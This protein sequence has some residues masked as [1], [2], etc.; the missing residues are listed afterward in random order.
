MGCAL[1]ENEIASGCPQTYNSAV[2][3]LAFPNTQRES[4]P[5]VMTFRKT[6]RVYQSRLLDQSTTRDTCL[7]DEGF[8]EFSV[9][10]ISRFQTCWR[11]RKRSQRSSRNAGNV[12]SVQLNSST[13]ALQKGAW[14]DSGH[15]IIPFPGLFRN[16]PNE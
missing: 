4:L 8:G 13:R 1:V 5:D 11:G 12:S 10:T 14:Y 7:H 9:R 16:A 6:W 3:P 2:M 15:G